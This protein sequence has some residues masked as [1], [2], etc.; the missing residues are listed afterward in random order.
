ME[1]KSKDYKSE[2]YPAPDPE[3]SIRKQFSPVGELQR[4]QAEAQAFN[5]AR[6]EA[7]NFT[8]VADDEFKRDRAERLAVAIGQYVAA[9]VARNVHM[10]GR[11]EVTDVALANLAEVIHAVME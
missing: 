7:Q 10:S 2:A 5:K 6:V 8:L 9:Y 3:T 4:K 1:A 11:N